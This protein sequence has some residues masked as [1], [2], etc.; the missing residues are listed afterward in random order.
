M[1]HRVTQ[2]RKIT[3][4]LDGVWWSKVIT[5]SRK[6]LSIAAG[7]KVS[8]PKELKLRFYTRT[9]EGKLTQLRWMH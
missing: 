9:T 5:K 8:L 6:K 4:A 2:A 3:D 1:Y 7:L